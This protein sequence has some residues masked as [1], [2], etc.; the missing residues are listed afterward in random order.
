MRRSIIAATVGTLML[1]G[2][3]ATPAFA[4]QY[5]AGQARTVTAVTVTSTSVHSASAHVR[6]AALKTVSYRGYVFQVPASWPVYNL[7]QDPSTCVRYDRHAVYLGTPGLNMQCPAGLIGRTETV[8]VIPSVTVAAGAGSEVTFQRQQPDGIGSTQVR[9]LP[10]VHATLTMNSAARELRVALGAAALTA[11]AVATYG[12]DP[13]VVE[14]VLATLRVA[15]ATVSSAWTPAASA[16]QRAAEAAAESATAASESTAAAYGASAAPTSPG[17]WSGLPPGWPV[18]IVPPPPQH[19][20]AP[21][22]PAPKKPAPKKPAPK[23]PVH[24]KPAPKKP[25]P[26]KPV[27]KKPVSKKPAPR[28]P[29]LQVRAVSGIDACTAPSLAAMRAWHRAYQAIGFYIGGE[30]AACDYG[31]LSPSWLR[32]ITSMGWGG[33]PIYVGPQAS[34]TTA[35]SVWEIS[36]RYAAAEGV[37]WGQD[38]VNDARLLGLG[39]GTP[40]YYDMEAYNAG[41]NP[42]CRSGVLTFLS[43]WDRTVSQAGY[44]TAVY[45]SAASG[46][47][48]LQNAAM[49]RRPGFTAPDAVW[50]AQWD[51]RRSLTFGDLPLAW[52]LAYRSKQY[53]GNVWQTIGHYRENVDLDLVGGPLAR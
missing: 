32:S 26:K 11:T 8:S 47:S 45:S 51:G 3:T 36:R 9:S 13:A 6:T 34:C 37:R 29:A 10:A 27:P 50:V 19:N 16:P 49:A 52:P 24:K 48:D 14:Q 12:Q 41:R 25:V 20:P 31:N 21:K 17:G 44:E 43:A 38:A 39:R 22:K 40:I 33:M 7:T 53:T 28:K 15:P 46:I 2:A 35:T 1:G 42:G 18:Q 5:G 23:K 30:N 4:A